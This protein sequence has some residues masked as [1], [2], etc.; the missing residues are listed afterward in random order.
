MP[1]AF[2]QSLILLFGMAIGRPAAPGATR[3]LALI[4]LAN[5]LRAVPTGMAATDAAAL[6]VGAAFLCDPTS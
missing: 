4:G 1:P 5:E 2:L 3:R 6:L